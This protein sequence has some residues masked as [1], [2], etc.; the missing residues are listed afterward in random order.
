MP[1]RAGE[2]D[3]ED[4]LAT[5]GLDWSFSREDSL[6]CAM[7]RAVS[8]SNSSALIGLSQSSSSS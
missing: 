4:G 3:C 6:E 5:G 2:C 1:E 8:G 7:R